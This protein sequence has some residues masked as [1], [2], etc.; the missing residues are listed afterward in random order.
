MCLFQYFSGDGRPRHDGTLVHH[1]SAFGERRLHPS[2]ARRRPDRRGTFIRVADEWISEIQ[3]ARERARIEPVRLRWLIAAA[4]LGMWWLASGAPRKRVGKVSQSAV[5]TRAQ[6]AAEI[7]QT[8]E[9]PNTA[10][11]GATALAPFFEVLRGLHPEKR[12]VVRI[13]HY[14]D[15][16]TAA[17]EWTGTLRG[18]FQAQ[19][20]DAGAGFSHAGRPWN[21]Y[22]R[23][24]VRSRASKRWHSEGLAGR[25]GDGRYGLSGVA[26]TAQRAGEWISLEADC[27]E[28]EL[29]YLRQ[30]SGGRIRLGDGSEI[31]T[32]GEYGAGYA[33]VPCDRAALRVQT[34]GHAPVRL[35]GWV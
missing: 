12:S 10:I 26:I 14:G 22:R 23:M 31:P 25:S 34:L 30:P 35:L 24:D 6:A 4:A 20:G 13:L 15:S 18:L 32:D 3:A 29:W 5:K 2:T 16:H 8:L 17:D 11:E 33:P 7:A 28:A 19:F 27:S 1:G 21:T 9:Q